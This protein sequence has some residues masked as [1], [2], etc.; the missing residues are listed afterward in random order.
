MAIK[1]AQR[2]L[3]AVPKWLLTLLVGSFLLQITLHFL[4]PSLVAR[5]QDLPSPPPLLVL[6]LASLGEPLALSKLLMLW[7][8]AYDN[9][10]G[11]SIPF[12]EL[13]YGRVEQWLSRILALDRRGQYPLLAAS[14]LYAEVPDP[15]KQRQMLDFVARQFHGDPARR[16]PWLAHGVIL[17]KHR[18]KDLDL[19][20][21]YAEALADTE[22]NNSIPSWARQM[23]FILLEDMGE[24]ESARI[25]IGGLLVSNAVTDPHEIHFLKERLREL[26]AR[27]L[28]RN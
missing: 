8:Q 15:P 5:A 2:S 14:R 12:R 28:R 16:W 10:P 7:L 3:R 25:L 11:I 1:I 19:A 4:Q 22:Q 18:L 9:Q 23:D 6:Q 24:L 17:A 13:D 26:E 27:V 20:L 21:K